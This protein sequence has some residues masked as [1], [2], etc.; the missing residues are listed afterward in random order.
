VSAARA[1]VGAGYCAALV[2]CG[3]LYEHPL[4]LGALCAAVLAAGRLAGAGRQLWRAARLCLL[5]APLVVLVNLLANRNGLTVFWRLG[6]VP[7][8]GQLDLTLEALAYGG[9]L[10][11]R[12]ALMV[13]V[14]ALLAAAVDVDA[15]L[16][17]ARRLS[18]RS[19]LTAV[20]AVRMVPVLARDARR[21]EEARRCRWDGGGTGPAARLAVLRAICAGTLDRAA[22][23]A[24]ALE[25]RGFSKMRRTRG[26]RLPWSR[27]DLAFAAAAAALVTIAIAAQVA[28]VA[29]FAAIPALDAPVGADEVAL[30]VALAIAALAPFAVRA[31]AAR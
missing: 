20:L 1:S 17:G 29:S 6:E 14:A 8:L 5:A 21:L 26:A 12:L 11:L 22:D 18:A 3:L 19:G 23:A 31:G 27:Q 4:V 10:A 30:T 28:G 24:A 25:V 7:P 13:L 9:A 16:L 15:L 2:A